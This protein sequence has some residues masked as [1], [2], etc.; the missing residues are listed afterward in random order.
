MRKTCGIW[1]A[2]GQQPQQTSNPTSEPP[3][4]EPSATGGSELT[5]DPTGE[6]GHNMICYVSVGSSAVARLRNGSVAAYGKVLDFLFVAGRG[7]SECATRRNICALQLEAGSGCSLCV[8]WHEDCV[9]PEGRHLP[10]LACYL[11][12]TTVSVRLPS[13]AVEPCPWPR[14]RPRPATHE[15]LS[16]RSLEVVPQPPSFLTPAISSARLVSPRAVPPWPCNRLLPRRTLVGLSPYALTPRHA[17]SR[18]ATSH[19]VTPRSQ[20]PHR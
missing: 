16:H 19:A 8:S 7:S 13:C 3:T 2:I 17:L 5:S 6:R 15:R 18:L 14:P 12:M 11:A 4:T 20:Q 9:T 10:C 1:Q